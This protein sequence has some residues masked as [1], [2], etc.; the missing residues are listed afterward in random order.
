MK[1]VWKTTVLILC[2]LILC[3][4]GVY[5]GLAFYYK[6]AFLYGTWIN[7][8]YCTGK[9]I[10]E[11][12]FELTK[13]FT[14]EGIVISDGNDNS[15]TISAN[16]IEYE[17]DFKKALEQYLQKQNS[18]TWIDGLFAKND[19][20]LVPV[21][22]YDEGKLEEC[23]SGIPFLQEEEL[24]ARDVKIEKTKKGYVLVNDRVHVLDCEQA[25]NVIRQ[26]VKQSVTTISLE[27][28][29]CY[30]D[31]LL[32]SKMEETLKMWEKVDAFQTCGIVYC[33][34]EDRIKI[35]ASVICDW[36]LLD[37]KDEFVLD[38][39][40]ELI[41]KEDAIQTFIEG[42]ASEYDTVGKKRRFESTRGDIV[43]V[44]GGVY[45]NKLDQKSEISYLED[46]FERRV[47]EEHVPRYLQ[48]GWCQGKNDIGDTYIEVD[49]TQQM[50]YYYLKG[51]IQIETPIVTGNTSLRRGTPEGVNFVYS[52]QKNR[53]LRGPGYASHVD[54]WMPVKGG[55][56]I[57]DAAWRDSYG[58]NIYKTNG[59]HG[60]INTPR[61]AMEE[62]YDI[63]EIGTPVVMF[64]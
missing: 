26:S 17:F 49:M 12:N 30:H 8:I 63:V 3:I 48:M 33:M 58:G 7:G 40:G 9:S 45:G 23:L 53:I 60:C 44:E 18:W 21:V 31:L 11:V 14:Y 2:I 20:S 10:D 6:N 51:K 37:E 54:F 59:S 61:D 13:D 55:I 15:Y 1:R 52:K 34:G 4:S 19:I 41:L 46:A 47:T 36:I 28:A 25:K 57:H 38:E 43:L 32:T 16:R 42:L 50:M 64:Y 29:G 62:L 27:E 39:D 5:V 35:D 22:V 24:G 56:G